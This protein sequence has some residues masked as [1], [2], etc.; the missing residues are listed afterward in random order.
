MSSVPPV[1]VSPG[2]GRRSVNATMSTLIEPTTRIRGAATGML[3][4]PHI[5]ARTQRQTPRDRQTPCLVGRPAGLQALAVAGGCQLLQTWIH[6]LREQAHR[7]ECLGIRQETGLA[8]HEQMAEPSGVFPEIFNLGEHLIRGP[9]K[10]IA[11]SHLLIQPGNQRDASAA[12]CAPHDLGRYR[13][14]MIARRITPMLRHF[15]GRHVPQHFFR[16]RTGLLRISP[17]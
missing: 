13:R 11:P 14:W 2:V 5:S 12:A 10:D 17:T 16:P 7:G 15:V 3:S 6:F 4:P 8:H 9:G 1:T